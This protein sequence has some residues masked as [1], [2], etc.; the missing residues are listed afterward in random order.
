[1]A[2]SLEGKVELTWTNKGQRLIAHE[3]AT[4]KPPYAWVRVSD[5]R[6]A[7]TRLLEEVARVGDESTENLWSE[8]TPYTL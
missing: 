5:F 2:R 8:A 1:M 7:E 4:A 6:V 3:D